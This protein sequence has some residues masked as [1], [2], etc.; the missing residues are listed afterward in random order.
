MSRVI[1]IKELNIFVLMFIENFATYQ[2]NI[3]YILQL[4][5]LS[6]KYL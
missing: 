3:I 6:K 5:P 1:T 4:K 2:S